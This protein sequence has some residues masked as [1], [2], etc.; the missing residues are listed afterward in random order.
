VLLFAGM[1]FQA[2]SPHWLVMRGRDAEARRVL[3]RLR[4]TALAAAR[5]C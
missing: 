5:C 2:E 1:L 4:A 3:A